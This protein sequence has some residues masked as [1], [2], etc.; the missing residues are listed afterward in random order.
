M[1]PH[2]HLCSHP[3]CG[4]ETNKKTT[5]SRHERSH[6][7][8]RPF[9]CAAEGCSYRA[10]TAANLRHHLVAH[11]ENRSH[12]CSE[13]GCKYAA[14]TESAL[15]AH[16]RAVHREGGVRQHCTV[17]GCGFNTAIAQTFLEHMNAHMGVKPYSCGACGRFASAYKSH[18]SRHAKTCTGAPSRRLQCVA[19]L[20]LAVNSESQGASRE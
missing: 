11:D 2:R 6:T 15:R 19:S 12:Q 3:G 14:K 7:D 5:L 17:E 8:D 13:K 16:G 18:F 10:H 4:Y 20:F 1:A 9:P